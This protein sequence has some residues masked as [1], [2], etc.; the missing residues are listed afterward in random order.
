MKQYTQQYNSPIG[1]IN[2]ICDEASILKLEL[3]NIYVKENP[4]DITRRA[5]KFL[6]RYFNRENPSIDELSF[7]LEGT[8]F[9]V[10]VWQKLLD[11][12]YGKTTTYG[13]LA[14]TLA[15]EKGIKKMS[16]RA[17]GRALHK[18]PIP[19][20]IPCHRVVGKNFKLVGYA[21]GIDVKQ[22]LLDLEKNT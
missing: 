10:L 16:P 6:D 3:N 22:F 21:L 11:I 14:K 5:I 12:K 19:I 9:Q 15:N 1:V 17:V 7:K 18:N 13:E 20:I 8:S 4:N 2:V